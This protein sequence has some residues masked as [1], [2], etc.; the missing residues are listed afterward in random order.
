MA[1]LDI[2]LYGSPVLRK[3]CKPVTKVTPDLVALAKDMLDTMYDG[4]GCGLAGPQIGKAI[5]LV[6]ID[7]TRPDEGETPEPHIMFNPEWGVEPDSTD[8]PYD[9]G[10]LSI[11]DIFCNVVRPGKVWTKFTDENGQ[12]VVLHNCEGILARCIQHECDHLEGKLFVD[13]IST[14]DRTMNQSRLRDM[15]KKAKKGE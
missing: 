4:G 12:E 10:C 5:R 13:V 1:L 15:A 6:V 3:N 8:V 14:A 2:K 7:T 9:E 11:P